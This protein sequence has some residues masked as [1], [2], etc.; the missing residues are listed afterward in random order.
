[1]VSVPLQVPPGSSVTWHLRYR[2]PDAVMNGQFLL[3][4][5][6]I[7]ALRPDHVS[8]EIQPSAGFTLTSL[9]SAL[10]ADGTSLHYEG[11]PTTGVDL[12]ARVAR[13]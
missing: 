9:S 6:P 2:Y 13:G 7:P 5:V 1:V 8:V 3:R 11:A 4:L 10:S 12:I